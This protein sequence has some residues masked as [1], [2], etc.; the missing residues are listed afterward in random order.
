MYNNH[1]QMPSLLDQIDGMDIHPAAPIVDDQ[2]LLNAVRNL[3]QFTR[4]SSQGLSLWVNQ[5]FLGPLLQTSAQF[6]SQHIMNMLRLTMVGSAGTPLQLTQQLAG[7]SDEVRVNARE[8][9]AYALSLNNRN[10]EAAHAAN[11]LLGRGPNGM[12]IQTPF[13]PRSFSQSDMNTIM[14][15]LT[16]EDEAVFAEQAPGLNT[17]LQQLHDE[18]SGPEGLDPYAGSQR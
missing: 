15:H 13:G 11:A 14:L 8:I 4:A 5:P 7:C 6:Q 12:I 2:H 18:W 10:F 17:Q 3:A 16:T 9:V 1:I